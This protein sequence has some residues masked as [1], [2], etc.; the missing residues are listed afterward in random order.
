MILICSKNRTACHPSRPSYDVMDG[1]GIKPRTACHPSRP[2]YDVMDGMG[3]TKHSRVQ[4]MD[5][6]HFGVV[7]FGDSST[8]SMSGDPGLLDYIILCPL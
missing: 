5:Y 7:R 8:T 2:S 3:I 6:D 4:L 1:M